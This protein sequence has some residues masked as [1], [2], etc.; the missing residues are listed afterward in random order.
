MVKSKFEFLLDIYKLEGEKK[1]ITILVVTLTHLQGMFGHVHEW[2][3]FLF[4]LNPPFS[5]CLTW[6]V[7][8]LCHSP[9]YKSRLSK[10]TIYWFSW[11][12]SVSYMSNIVWI[13][14][15]WLF[16]GK[17]SRRHGL[18]N[19]HPRASNS[20]YRFPFSLWVPTSLKWLLNQKETS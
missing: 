6:A 9:I 18:H 3:L 13:T 16:I 15:L 4:W 10:R 8:Y 5:K 17:G 7:H 2:F 14:S 19:A 12:E 20:D 1:K 11:F